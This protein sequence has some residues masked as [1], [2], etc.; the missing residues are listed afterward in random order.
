MRILG[1]DHGSMLVCLALPAAHAGCR[2]LGDLTRLPFPVP[3]APAAAVQQNSRGQRPQSGMFYG[4]S[5]GH[6]HPRV[7]RFFFQFTNAILYILICI[8]IGTNTCTDLQ[9]QR[10]KI[11]MAI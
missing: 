7:H 5:A 11:Q 9:T 4:P 1:S 3:D 8:S 2:W 6:L 10:K